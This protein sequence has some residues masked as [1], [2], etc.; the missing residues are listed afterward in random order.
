MVIGE[1]LMVFL[2]QH[3]GEERLFRGEDGSYLGKAE[4]KG[5]IL[6]DEID[7]HQ[8]REAGDPADR[9]KAR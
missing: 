7:R 8:N 1:E 4:S 6:L 9:E 3:R 2:A 5:R